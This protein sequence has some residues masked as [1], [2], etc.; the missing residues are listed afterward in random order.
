MTVGA[1][2]NVCVFLFLSFFGGWGGVRG[3]LLASLQPEDL[4]ST[5][6]VGT[7]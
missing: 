5:N 3:G 7:Q 6:S 2:G 4:V 1:F